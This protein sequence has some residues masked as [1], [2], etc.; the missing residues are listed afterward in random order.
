MATHDRRQRE[1]AARHALILAAAREIAEAEGWDAVTTR[2]LADRVEYSQP[3]LYSHFAGKDAI[4]AAVALNGF[5]TL[6][7]LLKQGADARGVALAYLDFAREHPALYDAMFAEP[8][9]L[10]FGSAETPAALRESFAELLRVTGG[11]E[12]RAEVF[13]STLHGLATLDRG[14]R[15]R[16]DYAGPRLD[17]LTEAWS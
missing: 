7:G 17:A 13:W 10:A 2:R 8:T 3:V 6:A 12:T 5:A 14:H 16:P 4:V 11:D 1:R 15:L 9:S